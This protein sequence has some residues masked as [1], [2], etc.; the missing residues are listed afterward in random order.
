MGC[1]CNNSGLFNTEFDHTFDKHNSRCQDTDINELEE[2]KK[3]IEELL[4]G[5]LDEALKDKLKD[6]ENKI[7]QIYNKL[8][9]LEQRDEELYQM[10]KNILD[11]IIPGIRNDITNLTEN[12]NTLNS[13]VE[14][15]LN[16]IEDGTIGGGV[17]VIKS[18]D[19]PEEKS[20]GI[21]W[22]KTDTE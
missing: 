10:I 8:D 22:I 13:K 16:Q 2:L 14:N 18:P 9:S 11:V 19:E 7:T 6:L 12:Y 4:D 5:M 17:K 3:L 20:E 21:I 15:I 1:N